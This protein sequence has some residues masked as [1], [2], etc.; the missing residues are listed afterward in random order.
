MDEEADTLD[1]VVE[2]PSGE[3]VDGGRNFGE[4]AIDVFLRE[5]HFDVKFDLALNRRGVEQD[6]VRR[7]AAA[8]LPAGD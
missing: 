2:L 8:D 3:R 4:R 7:D 6:F 5:E 1:E